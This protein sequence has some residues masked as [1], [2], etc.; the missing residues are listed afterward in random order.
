MEH[1]PSIVI[2]QRTQT[3][4][5]RS[6]TFQLYR[7]RFS[8]ASVSRRQLFLLLGFLRAYW[9]TLFGAFR[10]QVWPI[11]PHFILKICSSTG[12]C[13]PRCQ[14]SSLQIFSV[15][16]MLKMRLRQIFMKSRSSEVPSLFA[17]TSQIHIQLILHCIVDATAVASNRRTEALAS[18]ISFTFVV[19]SH[20][21]HS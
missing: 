4:A 18:V 17:F 14:S 13:F 20:Y 3:W 7:N 1:G 21:K 9:V 6:A 15:R 19:Y 8:S 5:F 16:Q 11:K 2:R 12:C 10:G